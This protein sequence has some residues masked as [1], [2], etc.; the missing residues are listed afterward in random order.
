MLFCRTH[1]AEDACLDGPV[2]DGG[3]VDAH[4]QLDEGDGGGEDGGDRAVGAAAVVP[5]R[6]H[7]RHV[8]HQDVARC[9]RH[10]TPV[11]QHPSHSTRLTAPI[12]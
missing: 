5:Q 1:P 7:P 9:G 11:T 6:V 2:W 3:A 4:G 10:A 8:V 12:I